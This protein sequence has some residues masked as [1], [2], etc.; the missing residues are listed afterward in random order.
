MK[1]ETGGGGEAWIVGQICCEWPSVSLQLPTQPPLPLLLPPGKDRLMSGQ[2]TAFCRLGNSLRGYSFKPNHWEIFGT[3]SRSGG[4]H[5]CS[6][7]FSIHVQSLPTESLLLLGLHHLQRSAPSGCCSVSSVLMVSEPA[8]TSAPT[9]GDPRPPADGAGAA[10]EL[11]PA[12]SCHDL[13]E[14]G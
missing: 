2:V 12:C 11:G 5:L 7:P 13:A 10:I 6:P 8:H 4:G 14:P 9:P 3:L 1:E